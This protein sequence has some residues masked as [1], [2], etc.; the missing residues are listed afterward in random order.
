MAV[1]TDILARP[2]FEKNQSLLGWAPRGFVAVALVV[3]ALGV[4]SLSDQNARVAS[5][6]SIFVM[7]ALAMNVLTG[8]TGQISLGHQAFLGLGALTAANVTSSGI[9]PADPFMFGVGIV[10]GALASAG[11]ALILGAIALRIR[12]LYLALVT[13]IFGGVVAATI[14]TLPSLNGRDAGVSAF[15]PDMIAGEYSYFVFTLVLVLLCVY[16]D[17]AL[18]RSKVG[19][20]LVAV[21]ENELVASAFGINVLGYKL[22][23]FTVS[24]AMAGLAGGAFA[25]R[26][27]L[28]SDKDF[29]D[30]AGF[31]LALTFV[32]IVVVGG[33]A[34]RAGVIAAAV[35][36]A[37][38]SPSSP[39]LDWVSSHTGWGTFY[40]D[41]TF[42]ISNVIGAV[43]LLQTIIMNPGG[44]GQVLRPFS[45]WIAGH[46]FSLHDPDGGSGAGG[47]DGS[48]VRA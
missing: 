4:P 48:S 46:K 22:L 41:H 40:D 18:R 16:V 5:Y 24:G 21:R 9:F 10:C 20:S 34:N 31:N 13:L 43:L 45:R 28:F 39:A 42:Y 33:L 2:S 6:A 47:M 12:G 36:F 1:Q 14:F 38:I 11:A 44:L 17:S 25:F 37:V 30:F 15:R 23:A 7:V 8:Y 29:L 32:V 19:R 26:S 35:F 3:A 27:Q